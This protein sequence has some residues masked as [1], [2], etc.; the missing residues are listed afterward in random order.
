MTSIKIQGSKKTPEVNFDFEKGIFEIKGKS[1][2]ENSHLFYTPLFDFLT[3]CIDNPPQS[4]T[5]NLQLDY[6]NTSSSKCILDI[7]KILQKIYQNGVF[8]I[9]NWYYE[10]DDE[11][12]LE[13]G[14][15]YQ[16][17]INIPFNYQAV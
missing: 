8:V 7:M 2:P 1:I 12:M 14:E 10:K 5:C 6:F 4:I 9:I 17:I 3:E 13:A 16:S 11:E 15:S